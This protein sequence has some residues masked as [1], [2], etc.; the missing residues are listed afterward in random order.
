MR[1]VL[2][3]G[4]GLES[5]SIG[6]GK[7]RGSDAGISL[8]ASQGSTYEN[9]ESGVKGKECNMIIKHQNN[10]RSIRALLLKYS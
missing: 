9:R 1:E 6:R 4:E 5:P 2:S 8:D 7:H 10:K 3:L